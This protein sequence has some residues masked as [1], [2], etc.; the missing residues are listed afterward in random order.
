MALPSDAGADPVPLEAYLGALAAL[1]VMGNMALRSILALGTPQEVWETVRL[2]RLP[3]SVLAAFSPKVSEAARCWPRDA[4]QIDPALQ[5]QRWQR[6]GIGVVSIG[7]PSYPQCLIGDADPP[8]VL[9]HRGDIDVLAAPRVA[10]IGTRKATGYGRRIAHE[11]GAEL[12]SA[13]VCVVSG[14]ALGIDAAAHHGVV[15]AFD[16]STVGLGGLAPVGPVAVVGGG[17]DAPGPATNAALAR[18]VVQHGVVLSEAPPRT[19]P[20]AWRFPVRNRI[21]AALAQV[22]VVVESADRGGSMLTVEQAQSRDRAVLA[23]PGPIDSAA[24]AGTNSLLADGAG[25]CRGIDDVLVT[26]GISHDVGGTHPPVSDS[27]RAPHG[28]AAR[29]LDALGFTPVSVESLSRELGFDVT[30]LSVALGEL[31]SL[32]WAQR[33]GPFVERVARVT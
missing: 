10:V 29:V 25:V 3:A 24:S 15:A 19:R 9:F 16:R 18:R 20:A 4:S 30:R 21:L 28:D 8:V 22:V 27:R 6:Q 11:L 5:W 23:V 31:E 1:P 14:L 26:L 13:G 33:R 17:V 7:S 12:A 2:G 32:R